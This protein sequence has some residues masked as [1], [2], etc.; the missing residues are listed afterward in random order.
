[1][2]ET[3][4]RIALYFCKGD[5]PHAVE[6]TGWYIAATYPVDGEVV[7]V[8]PRVRIPAADMEKVAKVL[9]KFVNGRPM[10]WSPQEG[11]RRGDSSIETV[12]HSANDQARD[13]V[14][15]QLANAENL[16]KRLEALRARASEFDG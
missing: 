6:G 2:S 9:D 7:E 1:V 10:N 13:L 4:L 15:E 3:D 12:V 14:Q 5:E 16:V 11:Y 8:V